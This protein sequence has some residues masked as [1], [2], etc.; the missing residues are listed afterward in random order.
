MTNFLKLQYHWLMQAVLVFVLLF[1][2]GTVIPKIAQADDFGEVY[3]AQA[4]SNTQNAAA[5]N[6]QSASGQLGAN[7]LS[8]PTDEGGFVPCGNTVDNPCNISHLF[9]AFIAIINYLIGMAGFVAVAFI[10][11]AGLKMVWATGNEGA[12]T[13]AKQQIS[14]AIVGLVLVAIAFIAINTIFAS[15]SLGIGVKNGTQVF[16]DPLDYI[17]T[18]GAGAQNGK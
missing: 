15:G 13:A 16:T 2:A 9:R 4:T 18:G 8:Q 10:V 12:M 6:T 11:Y 3:L 7:N 1:S 17:K 5:T 14:G